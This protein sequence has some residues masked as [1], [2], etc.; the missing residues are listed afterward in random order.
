VNDHLDES[1]TNGPPNLRRGPKPPAAQGGGA[2]YGLGVIGALVWYCR[3][4]EEPGEY[5]MAVLKALV[6]PAFLVYRALE[7]LHGMSTQDR[8]YLE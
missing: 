5:A 7:V 3:Q 4:A 1:S 2:V 6:W 8:G